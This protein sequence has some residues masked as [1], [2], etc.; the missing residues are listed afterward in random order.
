MKGL[1]TRLFIMLC[2][3]SAFSQVGYILV[4]EGGRKFHPCPKILYPIAIT[5]IIKGICPGNK[6]EEIQNIK[7]RRSNR[8][9]RIY[10]SLLHA[11]NV[12]GVPL[13]SQPYL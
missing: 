8:G 1:E 10:D 4:K 7:T 11:L 6:V 3:V 12:T 13:S 9:D 5:F 2:L